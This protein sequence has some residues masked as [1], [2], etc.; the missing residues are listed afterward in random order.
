MRWFW[1]LALYG[2]LEKV[3]G[4]EVPLDSRFTAQTTRSSTG[5]DDT[6]APKHQD[7]EHVDVAHEEAPPPQPFEGVDGEK[8]A[9]TDL[10][11]SELSGPVDLDVALVDK[12]DPSGLVSVG[13]LIFDG[14][15]AFS[16]NVPV[17]VGS[18]H[19][20]AFQDLDKD[21]PSEQDPY[22]ED[23]VEVAHRIVRTVAEDAADHWH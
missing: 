21:G 17:G 10:I 23:L 8:V 6:G 16:L 22:A 7:Q 19:V 1:L 9:I 18:L 2:C 12:D 4:D 11:H 13:K 3:T 14:P 20:A 5:S 15:G